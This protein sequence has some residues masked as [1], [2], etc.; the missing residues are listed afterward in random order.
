MYSIQKK[1]EFIK[2]HFLW[3]HYII[4]F[5]IRPIGEIKAILRSFVLQHS[6]KKKIKIL[7]FGC[8]EGIFSN[9][10]RD[11]KNISYIGV[12]KCFDCLHFAKMLYRSN[13]YIVS[14]E[15][16]SF[17][18]KIFD[19]IFLN[20]VLHHMKHNEIDRLLSEIKRVLNEDGFLIVVELISRSQQKTSL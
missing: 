4:Q 3:W 20:S 7:D 15:I 17:K 1:E 6:N 18:N 2:L 10:F 19:F 9:I 8:G 12:D 13:S 11:E 16:L 5:L 14:S